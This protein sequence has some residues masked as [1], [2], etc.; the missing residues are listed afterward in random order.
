MTPPNPHD[1]QLELCWKIC[2]VGARRARERVPREKVLAWIARMRP[3][4]P[5]SPYLD[6][7]AR[8]LGGEESGALAD[9]D[10]YPAFRAL[11]PERRSFWR[12]LVQSHPFACIAPGR[13][14]RERRAILS[15]LP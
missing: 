12:P 11:P 8:I 5:G 15:R 14:T 4:F 1:A 2:R 9:L 7:W 3:L 6:A 10:A 13:T